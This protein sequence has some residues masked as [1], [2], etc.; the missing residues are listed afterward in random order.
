VVVTTEGRW[1]REEEE[2]EEEE[3]TDAAPVRLDRGRADDNVVGA[4]ALGNA[5]VDDLVVKGRGVAE[6]E[7]RE[8]GAVGGRGVVAVAG[9]GPV[10]RLAKNDD[11]G[12]ARVVLAGRDTGAIDC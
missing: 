1:P 12:A 4:V 2:E 3:E 8:A 10:G 5:D 7:S 6:S 9:P 11:D